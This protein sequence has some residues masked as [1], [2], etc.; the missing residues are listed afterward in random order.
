MDTSLRI[1]GVRLSL[2]LCALVMSLT[3]SLAKGQSNVAPTARSHFSVTPVPFDQA[4]SASGQAAHP[5][6]NVAALALSNAAASTTA[7]PE[8]VELARALQ[9]D[10]DLIY[11]YV[12]DNI[13]FSP[14]FGVLKG[15]VGTLLDGR[16]DSFDQAALMVALLNQA[17]LTN[18]AISNVMFE[19]GQLQLTSAQLQSWLGVDSNPYSVSGVL[20]QGGIPATVS[21][22]GSATVGHVWVKVSISGT[23][24][25]FDPAFKSHT[26]TA[27][28]VSSL[29]TIM[30]Y[31][32]ANFI[33]DAS[34]TITAT[35]IQGINRTQLRND[36]TT[37]SSN[38]A[39]YIR[40]NAP[41]AGVEDIVG[42]GFIA[43]TPFANGQTVRQSTN[44]F[45]TG[46]PTDWTTIPSNY[47][48]TLSVTLPGSTAQTFNSD[49][50][51]GHRLSIF[52]NSS[53]VPTL[54]LDGVSVVSGSASTQG[55][56]VGIQINIA[57][58][59]ATFADQSRTQYVNAETNENSGSGGYVLLTGWDQVGRG[60]IEKHRK[61]LRQEI[62]AGGASTSEP[63]LG[64]SL[65]MLG[66]TWLAQCAAQQ[67][68]A[69]QLLGTAT[70][71]FYGVGIVGEAVGTTISSPYVDLPLNFIN[72][73]TRVNGAATQTP[74][75]L[76]AFL[77]IS[78]TSSA[79]ESATL[80]QSQANVAGF[81]AAS[82]VKLLDL[83]IQNGDTIF[84]INNDNS[85]A[86]QQTYTNTIRP[87]LAPNYNPGDLATI[88][89]YVAQGFRVI[90]PLHG[91]TAIGSWT[92]VGFKAMEVV[93][94]A[95]SYGELISG[96][97]SGG[98][99]GVYVPPPALV[100]NT[101]SSQQAASNSLT[102]SNSS[103][104][105]T[106]GTTGPLVGDPLDHQKG[107]YQLRV[108]D[109]WTG[110]INFPYGLS[111]E[112]SY[113]SSAQ[114][115][116][117]PLG[118][119]W[120]HNYSISA[121]P[122]SDGFSGMGESSPLSA[123]NSIVALYVSSNLMNG[124]ALTAQQNLESFALEIVVNRWFTDQL[125]QNVVNVS[126]GWNTEQFAKVA[127]GT[128]AG[129]LGSTAILDAPSGTLR[130]RTKSGVT[131]NFNT[132]GQISSW[133]NAAGALV[134]FAYT[135]SLLSTVSN[136]ATGRQL[137]FN[138]TGNL[139]SSISDGSRTVSYAY[140]GTNLATYTDALGQNTTYAYDTTGLQDTAGHLTQIFYPSHPTSAFVTVSYD[141]LGRV[142]QQ[143]DA[144]G[145]LSQ[146][147]IAGSRT[148][149]D[150]PAG[151]RNVWYN[152]PLGNVTAEIKDYG[153]A[154]HLNITTLNA[155]DAQSNLLVRMM[156]EGDSLDYAYDS[157]SNPLQITH[158]PKPGSTLAPTVEN[159][160]YVSPVA[161]LSNFE[162]VQ[163]HTDANRNVTT[164]AY[165]STSGNLT[166]ITQPAAAKPGAGTPT[167]I[168][169]FTYS[170]IG[171]LQ[172]SQDAE[173]R[174]TSY[175]Y[176]PTHADQVTTVTVDSGRLNLATQYGYDAFGE[177]NSITD[178]NGNV[179]TQT[180]DAMRRLTGVNA[181][182]SGVVTTYGYLPDG[183]VQTVTRNSVVPEVTTL[184]YT[185]SDK[186]ASVTDPS[187][188]AITRTY[189]VDDRLQTVTQP[190]SATANRQ[191]TYDYDALSRLTQTSDSTSAS[192]VQ[193]L[194]AL[195]YTPNG[196]VA[197]F[198]DANGHAITYVYDGLDRLSQ[199]AFP[200][201]SSQ[202]YQRDANGNLSQ[203]STRSGQTIAFAYDAL[204]RAVTKTPQGE[205]AG[206]VTYGYDLTGRLLQAADSSS[207]T[208]YLV[209]YDTAGRPISY[210]DQQGR[211]TT[212]GFDG[213]GNRNRLQWPANTN[214]TAQYFV[215]YQYDPLNRMTE[216][217]ENGSTS[218]PL[219]KYQW[220]SL[221]RL[222]AITY[223]DGTNDA[224][225]LYDAADN[226]QSLTQTF[227]GGQSNATFTYG[228][229]ENHQ[230]QS[231]TVSNSTFQFVPL[232]GTA[233][234]APADVN[235]GFTG[236]NG[237][238]LT[239]D[240]NHNLTFDGT[241]TLTYDV[242]NRLIQAQTATQGIV[243][244][245]YD[246]LGHRKQ[247][248][249]SALIRQFVR[250]GDDEIADFAG[251][252]VG[253]AQFLTI[254][255]FNGLPLAQIIPAAGGQ[256]EMVTYYHH[257]VLGSTVAATLAGVVSPQAYTYDAFGAPGAG[258]SLPYLFAGYRYD[259]E[260]G[261]YYLNARYYSPA[262]G[263]FMQPDP[264]GP[265]GGANLYAYANND[266]LNNL[267]PSGLSTLQIGFAGNVDLGFGFSIP[268]SI[269]VA[270]DTK[271]N[272]GTYATS[273]VAGGVGASANAGV[274]VQAST[275]PTIYDLSGPFLNVG[276]HGGAGAGGSVEYFQD[277]YNP[278]T[279][280]IS[281]TLGAAEG[282]SV[283]ASV[284]T[285]QV[286]SLQKCVGSA[287]PL[288]LVNTLTGAPPAPAK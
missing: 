36:L 265:R 62:N 118:A 170:T 225:S 59:W 241:N 93:G 280:G 203:V 278:S 94:T 111:F 183:Q 17:S 113:D 283:Q 196:H 232:T 95:F 117:G 119:G 272:I 26:W 174:T 149:I 86:S 14:L 218:S 211:N 66:Y 254:P 68:L 243:Q 252:G 45:E 138:Y 263:R 38:L 79:F 10:P 256:S 90:A 154:P 60:M 185:L 91:Q 101:G 281:I 198:T 253:T 200:D 80:E 120:T 240:G 28:I 172:T 24:Y 193:V 238:N 44:P 186:I 134:S 51:Y 97:L 184:G 144:N 102:I 8:I 227:S 63:V 121:L 210:T 215:T 3:A 130:Y 150:D 31:S 216:V 212:V 213:V 226:L 1:H 127:D 248:Q 58:P 12:H 40:T 100:A 271:G 13:E 279:K 104:Y 116:V 128:Y 217:D 175:A 145:N 41:M 49:D 30:G 187:G 169:A 285:T 214:G 250:A 237:V 179:T 84:D 188:S 64:E 148:E 260:A 74:N 192:A 50:I 132:S 287:N 182:V 229:L 156:P 246:P 159:F 220:D 259:S 249:L 87:Q 190:V 46:T 153:L 4:Q 96:G 262:L 267:D 11:Q 2:L 244:F 288:T 61:A 65:A 135:G 20:A 103:L 69:D 6:R 166:Q 35:T 82:T 180:F 197:S 122:G 22:D 18:S 204:N 158:T 206:Q 32:Q 33:A 83:G 273:G 258:G 233:S 264:I 52:F 239:Y 230:R 88:D 98:F 70:Q 261:L 27:G 141:T 286:C 71:Y 207:S 67:R 284:T 125:T 55:T 76:A 228:W 78:G 89:S 165:S 168:Q 282:A 143:T 157:L 75:S 276:F 236:L 155:Y 266:P 126:D 92:G 16:G 251:S 245:L 77:D 107:S 131:M 219:A 137:T 176:D 129:Q 255:G 178:A 115:L 277:P 73:P 34:P 81:S 112:R 257:D 43:P 56:P 105:S 275:A 139:I 242:E 136:T 201:S 235:N 194:E 231:T 268:V 269:G 160:T 146:A 124:Q 163:T 191:Q 21:S 171:L 209:G 208:P 72:T 164:F 247:K 53:F 99:G 25:V 19:F 223:G 161:A 57:I 108:E 39:A 48:A 199:E 106:T 114:Q 37:Y 173:G 42:G 177:V 205:T 109:L 85:T 270:I 162:E 221:S 274:N 202:S 5:T 234:Y 167:P 29:P 133:S 151:N 123:V 7:P 189:D 9:N 54:Y 15:P 195:S 152:D 110:A 23:P 222:S 224:Y 181:P 147:F 47:Y 140:S 142:N